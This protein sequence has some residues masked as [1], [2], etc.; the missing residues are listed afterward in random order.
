M[1]IEVIDVS[2]S[3]HGNKVITG[4]STQMRQGTVTAIQGPHSSGKR[5]LIKVLSRILWPQE[6]HVFV[7]AHLDSL[8]MDKSPDFF[9]SKSYMDNLTYGVIEK[10]SKARVEAILKELISLTEGEQKEH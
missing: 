2:M 4:F 6:G 10:Q 5:T 8:H 1:A 9:H 3:Y 7:P